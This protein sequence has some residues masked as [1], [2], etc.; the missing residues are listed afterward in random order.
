[1][2]C[3]Q[4]LNNVVSFLVVAL[5]LPSGAFADEAEK[6][7]TVNGIDLGTAYSVHNKNAWL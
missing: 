3:V 7:G 4:T 6:M 1:M 2:R 5:A